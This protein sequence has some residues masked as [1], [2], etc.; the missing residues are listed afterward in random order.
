MSISLARRLG[1]ALVLAVSLHAS[2]AR[3]AEATPPPY[4]PDQC[5]KVRAYIVGIL[6]RYRGSLSK[7]LVNS[8]EEFSRRK[9][10][11][12]VKITMMPGTRDGEAVSELKII[13][14]AMD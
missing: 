3:A 7:Q 13:L 14:A 6:T 9:C 2:P 1:V 12:S 11:R 10:D 4:T 5:Q 8:L